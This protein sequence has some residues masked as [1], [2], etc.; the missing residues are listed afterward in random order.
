MMF[1]HGLELFVV[2]PF[3]IHTVGLSWA[4][5]EEDRFSALIMQSGKENVNKK[6]ERSAA[7]KRLVQQ[8]HFGV[9]RENAENLAKDKIS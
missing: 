5:K 8:R 7:K 9:R 3:A 2:I 1:S 6:K 4:G